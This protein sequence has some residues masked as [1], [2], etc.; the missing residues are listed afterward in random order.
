MSRE[1][2]GERKRGE[3]ATRD[4]SKEREYSAYPPFLILPGFWK[5]WIYWISSPLSP[6]CR[7]TNSGKK[8][9]LGRRNCE[10]FLSGS[11]V[12]RSLL[13]IHEGF[14]I[15]VSE[16]RRATEEGAEASTRRSDNR[17]RSIFTRESVS[18]REGN[19][20]SKSHPSQTHSRGVSFQYPS[21][22]WDDCND[23]RTGWF[24]SLKRDWLMRSA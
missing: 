20:F 17:H 3:V 19:L 15:R 7:S 24:Q 8:R 16:R 1:R 5:L 11:F 22:E 13:Y 18:V 23:V 9:I 14:A 12:T 21:K 10:N 6:P 4:L 2:N